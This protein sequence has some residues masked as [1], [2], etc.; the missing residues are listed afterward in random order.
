MITK[1]VMTQ[2]ANL[3]ENQ[4]VSATLKGKQSGVDFN[5]MI[6]NSIKASHE[7]TTETIA[8]KPSVSTKDTKKDNKNDVDSTSEANKVQSSNSANSEQT[9]VT[10]Q[11][12]SSIKKDDPK[13]AKGDKADVEQTDEA[14]DKKV[15]DQLQAMLQQIQQ[16]VMDKLNLS[17]E[18]LN[19]L[20]NEQ[21][22]S[23]TDLFQSDS[24]Q[25]LILANAG[26]TDILAVL[27]DENLAD[28]MNQLLL[29]ADKIK[30]DSDLNLTDA[31]MKSII[32]QLE[33]LKTSHTES[34]DSTLGTEELTNAQKDSV[35]PSDTVVA[36]NIAEDNKD[37]LTTKNAT[38]TSIQ[39][40]VAKNSL[41]EN[42]NNGAQTNTNS[43][44]NKDLHTSDQFQNF[45]D[46]LVNSS[47]KLQ[48]DFADDMTQVTKLREIANQII[49]RIKVSVMPGSTSMELQLNP[50]NLGKVNLT[51]QS[52]D[53]VMTAHFVVQNEISKEAIE[54]QIQTLRDTLQQQGVKVEAIEVTVSANAFEQNSNTGSDDEAEAQKS[55][56]GKQITLEDALNM[57]EVS[58]DESSTNDVTGTGGLVDYTA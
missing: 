38:E 7:S 32:D 2:A 8:K 26:Q 16:V 56:S 35:N 36:T 45:V 47:Q 55:N 51:V 42:T 31:Q 52:K 25:Q 13:I 53:G 15:A 46:N 43:D 12:S 41:T 18:D 20:L 5:L 24:L 28:T 54:S 22:L 40:D 50:E 19:Q 44:S 27:T 14:A 17:E 39:G 30:T 3:I 58:D 29:S 11:K 9:K 57:T 37:K 34:V 23:L 4:T 1:S 49:E 33:T 10:N 48:S 21:G 6:G